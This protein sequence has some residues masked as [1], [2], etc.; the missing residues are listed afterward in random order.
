MPARRSCLLF[1]AML[2]PGMA[3]AQR[4]DWHGYVDLRAVSAADETGWID[5][6][7]GKTRFGGG[8]GGVRFGGAA[9]SGA[10][11]V[12]PELL[13]VADVQAQTDAVQSL[14]LLDAWLRYRPVSITPWRWSLKAGAFFAPISLEND[15]IGWTSRWTLT[16]SAINSW[17]GE[18]LRTIGAEAR[19]EHR[20]ESRTLEAA[21]ALFG[22]NSPAGELLAAR[23]WSLSDY[24]AGVFAHLR[25]PDVYAPVAREDVPLTYPP[26]IDI[27]HRV[28]WY[29]QLRAHSDAWGQLALLRYDNRADPER[30]EVVDSRDL[31]GWRTRFWSLGAQTRVGDVELI[32][33]AMDGSTAFEPVSGLYLDTRFRAGYLLAAWD[34]GAWQPVLRVDRFRTRQLPDGR[35]HPLSE[36][37]HAFT[38]A[39][40]W[41][42]RPWLRVT[43]EWLQVDSDRDQR[44]LGSLSSR[45]SNRQLQLSARLFF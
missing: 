39:L 28:G 7:L 42:P 44:E 29:A 9:L 45:Q 37:G 10:W 14:D 41:R 5:G 22:R 40:N 12:T 8:D 31:F 36:H 19:I 24:T 21:I 6:G 33:Q 30:F 32:G 18:E 13:A 20:G 1:F 25:E 4:I 2:A 26:Y 35:E 23:G 3:H 16:P 27:D 38:V 15:G 17:V 34:R 11:Q 43:G